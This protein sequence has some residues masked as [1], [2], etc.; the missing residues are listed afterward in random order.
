MRMGLWE[1]KST[2]WRLMFQICLGQP[3]IESLRPVD[4]QLPMSGMRTGADFQ[5]LAHCAIV[6][7][8]II[9][10]RPEL[11]VKQFSPG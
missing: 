6:L 10:G 4:M 5:V 8:K 11:D 2:D 3:A 7:S 9:V 1:V